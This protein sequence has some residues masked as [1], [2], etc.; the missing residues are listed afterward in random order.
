[1]VK[2][3]KKKSTA[4]T[5]LKRSLHVYVNF[6]NKTNG[7]NCKKSQQLQVFWN[8]GS[9]HYFSQSAAVSLEGMIEYHCIGLQS[10]V[11]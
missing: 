6:L 3:A 10:N 1:M 7:Q 4:T 11:F 8:G 5:I 9:I 2:I